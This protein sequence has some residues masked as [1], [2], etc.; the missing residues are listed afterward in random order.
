MRRYMLSVSYRGCR[1][2]GW[3]A[4][5][6]LPTVAGAV[7][8]AL[9]RLVGAGN[10]SRAVGSSRTDR[11]VHALCNTFHVDITRRPRSERSY[12]ASVDDDDGVLNCN[13]I[14][15]EDS[16]PHASH[17]SVQ[18]LVGGLNAYIKKAGLEMDI[19]ILGAEIES[20]KD[21]SR[22]RHARFSARAREYCYRIAPKALSTSG[23][24]LYRDGAASLFECNR[25][26]RLQCDH[27]NVEAMREAAGRFEGTH[28]FSSFRHRDCTAKSPVKTVHRVWVRQVANTYGNQ[29]EDCQD[30]LLRSLATASSSQNSSFV[31][32]FAPAPLLVIDVAAPSFLHGMVR[33]IVGTLVEVGRGR[34]KPSDLDGVF[35]A[36]NRAAAPAKAPASG[37]FL[38]QVKY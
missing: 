30:P 36:K 5:T 3:Q 1:F 21:P 14:H 7:D 19:R 10:H 24:I 22:W 38:A 9:D 31:P 27:L 8:D 35:A 33:N 26:W 28:D 13:A 12:R 11:G 2:H 20:S 4:Q 18:E 29:I 25:A 16:L 34:L 15:R 17:Y 32:H 37:L 6:G 23:A